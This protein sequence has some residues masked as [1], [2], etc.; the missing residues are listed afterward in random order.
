MPKPIADRADADVQLYYAQRQCSPQWRAFLTSLAGQLL[1]HAQGDE[2]DIFLREV[3]RGMAETL[4]LGRVEGL[5]Q[6]QD[7]MNETLSQIDWGWVSLGDGG[8]TINIYHYAA[9][10]VITEDTH[11]N[12]WRC[13]GHVLEGLYGQWFYAQGAPAHLRTTL[14]SAGDFGEFRLC[15]G[16]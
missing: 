12:W 13:M 14:V 2:A 8:Q 6:L 11:R 1:R 7:S 15:H 4:T 5:R 16:R 9:P 10:A 3:G